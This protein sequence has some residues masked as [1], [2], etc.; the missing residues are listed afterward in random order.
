MRFFVV[1][2]K[3]TATW[4]VLLIKN[5]TLLPSFFITWLSSC[6][7]I[8]IELCILVAVIN[9]FYNTLSLISSRLK[10]KMLVLKLLLALRMFLVSVL[11]YEDSHG[12]ILTSLFRCVHVLDLFTSSQ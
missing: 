1:M 5:I 12:L 2:L 10:S 4:R 3:V 7:T 11:Q 6:P 9:E 8:K